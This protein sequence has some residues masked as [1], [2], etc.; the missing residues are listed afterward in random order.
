MQCLG[1][2]DSGESFTADI[3]FSTY[4]DGAKPKLAAIIGEVTEDSTADGADGEERVA[5]NE[6]ESDVMRLLVQ[7]LTNK[8]IAARLDVSE[9]TVKN[10][11]QQLFAKSGVRTRSQLV[12]VALETY[13][14]LL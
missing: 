6:R 4:K 11:L 5:L 3:W 8:E 1:H 9:G 13:R 10:I 14:D 7:G 2:R 12:R